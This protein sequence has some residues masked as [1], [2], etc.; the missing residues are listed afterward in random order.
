MKSPTSIAIALC[1]AGWGDHPIEIIASDASEAAL[2]KARERI[3]RERSFRS[4]PES[5]RDKYFVPHR[6]HFQLRPETCSKVSFHW[7]NLMQVDEFPAVASMQ[8]IFCRNVFI[9]FFQTAIKHVVRSFARRLSPCGHLFV[10]ASEFLLKLISQFELQEVAGSFAY[11]RNSTPPIN[12]IRTP[13]K[14][15]IVDDSAFARKVGREML[16]SSPLIEVVGLAR[17]GAEALEL[18]VSL[19]PHLVV[20]DLHMPVV[21]GV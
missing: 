1:E 16:S 5:L 4:L 3:Y 14:V 7:A 11:V 20:C 21:N 9:Y 18:A 2:L 19:A 15:L 17:D 8:V 13:V 10:G 12:P 6:E